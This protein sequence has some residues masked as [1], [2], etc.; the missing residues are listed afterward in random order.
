MKWGQEPPD[1][2][3]SE[4]AGLNLPCKKAGS[5]SVGEQEGNSRLKDGM[6][7]G[8]QGQKDQKGVNR[9]AGGNSRV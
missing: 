5:R 2:K 9:K 8:T 4:G 3:V 7:D 6:D 1:L